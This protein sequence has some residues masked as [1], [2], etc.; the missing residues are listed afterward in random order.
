[1]TTR[2]LPDNIDLTHWAC[3]P[4]GSGPAAGLSRHGAAELV[5]AAGEGRAADAPGGLVRH[6]EDR[7]SFGMVVAMA[8]DSWHVLW[9]KAPVRV[10]VPDVDINVEGLDHATF[11]Y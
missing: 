8:N 11:Q 3:V 9:S 7:D 4:I 6:T 10:G 5:P 1:M 2:Y